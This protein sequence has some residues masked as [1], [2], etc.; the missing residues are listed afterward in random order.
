MHYRVL[1]RIIIPVTS[2]SPSCVVRGQ[3]TLFEG[4]VRQSLYYCCSINVWMFS[5]DL[6][7]RSWRC[8]GIECLCLLLFERLCILFANAGRV[9]HVHIPEPPS[10]N[11][12][13]WWCYPVRRRKGNRVL[14]EIRIGR[15]LEM[16]R[17]W[18]VPILLLYMWIS[19]Q[20]LISV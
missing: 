5:P 14:H 16:R 10:H 17:Y 13:G 18:F 1:S 6:V 11:H 8:E 2:S 19:W 4:F 20:K 9:F 15:V 3:M 12:A 7:W